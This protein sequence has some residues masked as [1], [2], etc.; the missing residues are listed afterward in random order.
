MAVLFFLPYPSPGKL[1]W[2]GDRLARR[3][4]RR[5]PGHGRAWR[6]RD[7]ETDS[8]TGGGQSPR[9][10]GWSEVFKVGPEIQ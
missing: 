10:S 6:A 9:S 5:T 4:R 1:R 7:R 2:M 3:C 8:G